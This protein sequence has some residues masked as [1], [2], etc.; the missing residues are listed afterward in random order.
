MKT[1]PL[2]IGLSLV[3][4]AGISAAIAVLFLAMRAVMSVGGTCASGGPYQIRVECPDAIPLLM[5]LSI[6]GG[7]AFLF[8]FLLTAPSPVR[9]FAVLAWT[10][11]FGALG[12][13]FFDAGLP[14]HGQ[15]FA[16]I[17]ILLG[18]MFWIM[19][20][21][22]LI[23]LVRWM[24]SGTPVYR[25]AQPVY[26]GMQRQQFGPVVTAAEPPAARSDISES[27]A[28]LAALHRSGELTD[29]EYAQAKLSLL[30]ENR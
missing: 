11:L 24:Q 20:V 25:P 5:P 12:W 7:I 2:R 22:P 16:L 29:D 26:I 9:P 27:L 4:A 6:L 1:S 30:E 21:V 15:E 19:A 18:A 14:W 23:V 13:N 8:L 17:G 28:R 3:G 10:G